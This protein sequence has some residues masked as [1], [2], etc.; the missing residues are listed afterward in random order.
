MASFLHF[1]GQM[2]RSFG[3]SSRHSPGLS[4]NFPNNA[5]IQA[6]QSRLER[7]ING[8]RYGQAEDSKQS[9]PRS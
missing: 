7:I 5:V 2:R 4:E 9:N 6:E 8:G 3:L 1:R